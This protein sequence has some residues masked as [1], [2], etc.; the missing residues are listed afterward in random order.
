ML[1]QISIESCDGVYTPAQDSYLL[2]EVLQ[3]EVR[4]GDRVVDVGTGS[5]ILA[6]LSAKLGAVVTATDLNVKALKCALRNARRNKVSINVVRCDLL[7]GIKACF[8]LVV[9]NPPYLPEFKGEPRDELTL[10]WSGG[11]QGKEVTL[12]FLEQVPGY[13]KAGSRIL[14]LQ[15]SFNPLEEVILRLKS[16]CS[17]IEIVAEKSFFFERLYVLKAVV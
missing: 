13:V 14:L 3:E 16:F 8:D 6:V 7:S 15:S 5:G 11:K 12:R 4:K 2:A 1:S 9:F 17:S 10:A